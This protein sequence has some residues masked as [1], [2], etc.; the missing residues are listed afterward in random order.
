[1]AVR[2]RRARSEFAP[3]GES[4]SASAFLRVLV[5]TIRRLERRPQVALQ[6]CTLRFQRRNLLVETHIRLGNRIHRDLGLSL[7]LVI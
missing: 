4:E 7:N 6:R 3:L 2:P 5:R 1:M